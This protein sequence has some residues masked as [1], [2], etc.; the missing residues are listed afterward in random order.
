MKLLKVCLI[1]M[2]ANFCGNPS[3]QD[4]D[5]NAGPSGTPSRII[6]T[7]STPKRLVLDSNKAHLRIDST[8]SG[9]PMTGSRTLPIGVEADSSKKGGNN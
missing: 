6:D 9:P 4:N 3:N 1:I 2:I 7:V 8:N 5:Q